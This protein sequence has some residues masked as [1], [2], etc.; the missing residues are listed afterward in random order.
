MKPTQQ[1]LD[2]MDEQGKVRLYYNMSKD[3]L[4]NYK[5]TV[6]EH[7]DWSVK[8]NT[9]TSIDGFC[10][11]TLE[12]NKQ[13]RKLLLNILN[14]SDAIKNSD[15]HIKIP[16]PI[17]L[18]PH[19]E[20][21]RPPLNKFKKMTGVC[22]NNI[23]RRTW[24]NPTEIFDN[25]YYKRKKYNPFEFQWIKRINEHENIHLGSPSQV[26]TEQQQKLQ[27]A[28]TKLAKTLNLSAASN[29]KPYQLLYPGGVFITDHIDFTRGASDAGCTCLY[30]GYVVA[31]VHTMEVDHYD[32]VYDLLNL[33]YESYPEY[34]TSIP[35]DIERLKNHKAFIEQK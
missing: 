7:Y 9:D 10:N 28:Y 5:K 4:K 2:K 23:I 16:V 33:V 19:H 11:Y 13:R 18:P 26:L 22:I 15:S 20:W 14:S 25:N 35:A 12:Q 34:F 24:I 32:Q 30:L 29:D 1:W 17:L 31:T 8:N 21:S 27:T 6:K 3:D